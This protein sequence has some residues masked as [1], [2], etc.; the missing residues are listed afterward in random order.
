MK[1]KEDF[2]TWLTQTKRKKNGEHY[3]SSTIDAYIRTIE[4]IDTGMKKL[5]IID[6]S[7]YNVSSTLELDVMVKKIVNNSE[8][9]N[10]IAEGIIGT[11]Q[12]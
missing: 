5:R 6:K 7:L 2:K 4:N 12:H 10:K 1:L 11:V 9:I 3:I 8:Y